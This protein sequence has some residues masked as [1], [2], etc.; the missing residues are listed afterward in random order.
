MSVWKADSAPVQRK[1]MRNKLYPVLTLF[2]IW[3][4]I[5]ELFGKMESLI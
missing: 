5:S 4:I 3:V 2:E 1:S